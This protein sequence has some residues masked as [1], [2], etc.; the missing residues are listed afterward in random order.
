MASFKWK[1][2]TRVNMYCIHHTLILHVDMPI[3]KPTF[4]FSIC[5]Y[6]QK[7]DGLQS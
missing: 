4:V 6:K 7:H 3:Q 5:C 1:G 2:V